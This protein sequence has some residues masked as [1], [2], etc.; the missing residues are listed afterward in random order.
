MQ[1]LRTKYSF[2]RVIFFLA[3]SFFTMR[4]SGQE[5]IAIEEIN[6][7]SNSVTETLPFDR[8]I[9]LKYLTRESL[10]IEYIGLVQ[11]KKKDTQLYY[12]EL[13]SSP[14]QFAAHESGDYPNEQLT[15]SQTVNLT[16]TNKY[17]LNIFIP[18]L[19]PNRFYDISLLRRP[20]YAEAELYFDLFQNYHETNEVN[21]LLNEK[22]RQIN[23]IKK[24]FQHIIDE[25]PDEGQLD[26]EPLLVL[27][28]GRL[29][30]LYT[31]LAVTAKDDKAANVVKSAITEIIR[32]YK[33]AAPGAADLFIFGQSLRLSTTSLN[34][35]T[36][37]AFSITPD[38]GY[39]Y[40]GYQNEFQG[41]A[42]YLGAQIEFRYFDKDIPFRLIANKTWLH[43]LSFTTGIT[44]T[45]VGKAGKRDDFFSGKSLLTGLGFRLSN[46]IRITAGG[47]L[48]YKEDPDPAIDNKKLNMTPFVGISIDLRLKSIMGDL[49]DLIPSNTK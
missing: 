26:W 34:F 29:K 14:G 4:A 24:P 40:Y 36:R 7:V 15:I 38:F 31:R 11:I 21:E 1:T 27:Y 5:I 28:I 19:S 9:L 44:L 20:T 33:P 3:F 2:D 22:L 25:G 17:Q 45:S 48:F 32:N 18:P 8:P 12:S 10:Q 46:A 16:G 47:I 30:E 39:V 13:L 43:Y 42:P 37:T 41:L 49:T 23:E 35:D 6:G